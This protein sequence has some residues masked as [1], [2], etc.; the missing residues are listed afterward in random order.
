MQTSEV[1]NVVKQAQEPLGTEGPW[2]S[3]GRLALPSPQAMVLPAEYVGKISQ[4]GGQ[5]GPSGEE[6]TTAN[7]SE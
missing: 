7:G 5:A 6:Y 3:G 2:P 1:W 4:V